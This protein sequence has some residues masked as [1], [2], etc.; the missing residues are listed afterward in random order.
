MRYAIQ[1]KHLTA[2][3]QTSVACSD[4]SVAVLL[5]PSSST[6]LGEVVWIFD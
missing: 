5:S 1:Q 2:R 3:H 4:G 6:L